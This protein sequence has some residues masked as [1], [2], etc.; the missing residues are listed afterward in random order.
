M[1]FWVLSILVPAALAAAAVAGYSFGRWGRSTNN[2][3]LPR[4]VCGP[5]RT[6][7]DAMELH[8]DAHP[9]ALSAARIDLLNGTPDRRGLDAA[10]VTQL[11][12]MTRYDTRFSLAIF[13]IDHSQNAHEQ[14]G[15]PPGDRTLRDLAKLLDEYARETDILAR[16]GREQFAI[17]MP[18]TDLE[19][20]CVLADRFRE[21]VERRLPLT[22]SGG[23]TTAL[24]GDSREL[25]WARA[26]EA[27]CSA[28]AAG[29]NC[30]F[31]QNGEQAR[32]FKGSVPDGDACAV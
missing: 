17:V 6:G 21:E 2:E 19:G 28:K 22:I 10:L 24:D 3:L 23:V 1:D 18:E 16:A 7:S 4:P 20:A 25:L 29:P 13:E 12:Q 5:Q 31:Q 26:D 11:A 9:T 15:C 8:T 30:V 32:P 14:Q 27:L